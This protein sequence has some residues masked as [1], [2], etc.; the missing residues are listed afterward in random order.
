M[1]H[2]IRRVG[3][4]AAL[5]VLFSVLGCGAD[6]ATTVSAPPPEMTP[7]QKAELAKK[8]TNITPHLPTRN[9]CSL[10]IDLEH[11]AASHFSVFSLFLFWSL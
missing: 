9:A 7:E 5:L 3:S 1:F 8:Q 11:L 2:S 4:L 10:R 6:N